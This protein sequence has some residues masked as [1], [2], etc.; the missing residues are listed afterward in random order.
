MACVRNGSNLSLWVDGTLEGEEFNIQNNFQS[1]GLMSLGMMSGYIGQTGYQA[2]PVFI[3]PTRFSNVARYGTR[4]TPFDQWPHDSAT[5]MQFL[6]QKSYDQ[7]IGQL[8]DEVDGDNTCTSFGG[9]DPA[10]Q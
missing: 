1:V 3:G 9:V 10:C 2:A 7:N 4:F 8:I 5:V 6:V